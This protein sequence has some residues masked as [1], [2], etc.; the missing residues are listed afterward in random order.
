MSKIQAYH[1]RIIASHQPVSRKS[2][3]KLKLE[4][5]AHLGSSPINPG[6][7]QFIFSQPLVALP[8]QLMPPTRK[9]VMLAAARTPLSR[10]RDLRPPLTAPPRCRRAVAAGPGRLQ[11]D[12]TP[13]RRRDAPVTVAFGRVVMPS[14]GG[15]GRGWVVGVRINSK[16]WP[17][18]SPT[19]TDLCAC[20]C[21]DGVAPQRAHDKI[22]NFGLGEG[23]AREAGYDRAAPVGGVRA[24]P[25]P[26]LPPP[27]PL[28][29]SPPKPSSISSSLPSPPPPPPAPAPARALVKR[30]A[31]RAAVGR[32]RM[33]PLR[34]SRTTRKAQEIEPLIPSID[35]AIVAATVSRARTPRVGGTLAV[36]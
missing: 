24:S 12:L 18:P 9:G 26:P 14:A 32:E 28:P 11:T 25:L 10:Q 36:L 33:A 34:W 30:R 35:A 19:L 3:L 31:S 1:S 21:E 29:P 17:P 23:V 15:A 13:P 16:L 2:W 27:P 8:D 6:R 22:S 4:L 5:A 7:V 20:C